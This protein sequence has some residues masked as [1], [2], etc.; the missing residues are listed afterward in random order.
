MPEIERLSLSQASGISSFSSAGSITWLYIRFAFCDSNSQYPGRQIIENLTLIDYQTSRQF[1]ER[2][3]RRAG[4]YAECPPARDDALG[5]QKSLCKND[6]CV[7]RNQ[8]CIPREAGG[9][10]EAAVKLPR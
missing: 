2:D 10:I 7:L 9:N 6:T 4:L 5:M 3:R 8:A 1:A